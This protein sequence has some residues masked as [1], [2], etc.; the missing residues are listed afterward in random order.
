MVYGRHKIMPSVETTMDEALTGYSGRSKIRWEENKTS[1]RNLV[2]LLKE[3]VPWIIKKTTTTKQ[4]HR[5]DC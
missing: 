5:D 4:Q 2:S 3:N 1:W